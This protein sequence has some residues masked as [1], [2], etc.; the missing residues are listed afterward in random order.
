MLAVAG[1]T[2]LMLEGWLAS[3]RW[4]HSVDAGGMLAV[5]GT[6]LLMM[7]GWLATVAVAGTTLLMQEGC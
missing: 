6:T 3:C 4:Y 1:N 5:A 7:E 2:V